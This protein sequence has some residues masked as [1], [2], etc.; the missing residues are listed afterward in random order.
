MNDAL[1]P[2]SEAEKNI[3]TKMLC[4]EGQKEKFSCQKILGA[5]I[6]FNLC[7]RLS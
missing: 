2:G 4:K 5:E 1:M 6:N 3:F 7:R